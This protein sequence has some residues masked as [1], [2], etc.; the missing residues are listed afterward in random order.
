M[1]NLAPHLMRFFDGLEMFEDVERGHNYKAWVRESVRAFLADETPK[2]ALEVY[3]AFFD[4]YRITMEGATNPFL[5]LVDILRSY[6][7]TAATLIEKQRDHYVHAVNVFLTGLAIWAENP[8]LRAAFEAAIPEPGYSFA[9]Q[10]R[11][12]E[13]FYRWGIASLFHDVGYPVEIVGHQINRFIGMVSDADGDEVRVRARIHYEHFSELNHIREVVHKR[14]FTKSYYDAYDSCSYIDLLTPLDL[15]AH[16]IYLAFGCDLAQTKAALD[17]F[18]DKMAESGFIDHGYYSALIILKWYGYVIQKAGYLPEYFFWPVVDSA[19]AIL[20]HNWYRN[21]LAKEPFCLGPMHVDD[22]PIAWLLILCDELQEWNRTARGI[23]TRTF[24]LAEDVHLSLT[25][26]YLAATFVTRE[27]RLPEG[28][29]AEKVEL[30]RSLLAL[31]EVFPAGFDVD[32]ES[33]AALASLGDRL[34]RASGRPLLADIELL[35]IAI[36]ASYNE[37]QLERHPEQPLVYPNFSDLPDDLKYS[38][39]RQAQNIFNLVQAAGFELRPA[40]GEGALS[41]F[42]PEVVEALARMEHDSWMAERKASGWKL[43]ARDVEAKTS[44]YLVDYDELPDDVKELDR[45]AVRNIPALAARIGMGVY[46][47]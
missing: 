18:V 6:E 37:H 38:N 29:C 25:E 5:D 41:E 35:A 45:D 3:R 4:A 12:E 19:T 42:P 39:M 2:R 36:H 15:M 46:S 33:R 20:L 1:S 7:E 47:A 8:H 10:T 13:F 26:N 32:N 23:V 11:W 43:G 21:G 14:S 31:D 9:Y 28:F 24:T 27:G 17:S 34:E 44:P 30:L 40:K 16:R 22:N